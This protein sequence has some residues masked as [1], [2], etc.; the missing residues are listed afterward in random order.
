M[1][2]VLSQKLSPDQ[3]EGSIR[4]GNHVV[5]KRDRR[6]M[7][8]VFQD[9]LMLSN[10]TVRETILTSAELKLPV[11][12]PS[13]EK[14][15]RVDALIS[16]LGLSKV[17]DQSIGSVGQ[18][19]I[20][21]GER[22]RTAVANELV[23]APSVLFLD[24]PTSGLD[25]TTALHLI[26]TLR[27]LCD[28]GMTII[29]C[30]H[31]PRENIFAQFDRLL[32]L[33]D[34]HTAFF[35]QADECREYLENLRVGPDGEK[36]LELPPFTN[37]ADWILD[38]MS[39]PTVA[40]DIHRQWAN[41]QQALLDGQVDEIRDG[42][43]VAD[44]EHDKVEANTTEGVNTASSSAAKVT[45]SKSESA[46]T[47]LAKQPPHQL[48][49][50][51]SHGDEN[52]EEAEQANSCRV[53]CH[54]FATLSRRNFLQKRGAIISPVIIVNVLVTGIITGIMYWQASTALDTV[55]ALF[56]I[57]INQGYL[58][59]GMVMRVFP[60]EKFLMMR[61][62]SS[63]YYTLS[64]YFWAK[65]AVD[66]VASWTAPT[67]F[68]LIVY[69]C[70][71]LQAAPANFFLVL[72]LFTMF[73]ITAESFGFFISCAFTNFGTAISVNTIYLL[74]SM[75]VGGFYVQFDL[76]P[77]WL[78][79]LK[80]LGFITY[81]F[82]GLLRTQF[83]VG[84]PRFPCTAGRPGQFGPCYDVDDN[85]SLFEVNY[86]NGTISGQAILEF[87]STP[88]IA[89]GYCFLIL[90]LFAII[91]RFAA[92]LSLRFCRPGPPQPCCARNRPPAKAPKTPSS[93]DAPQPTEARKTKVDDDVTSS[94][95]VVVTVE[96]SESNAQ[97][98]MTDLQPQRPSVKKQLTNIDVSDRVE[99][100]AID[101]EN[102]GYEVIVD[103]KTGARRRILEGISGR[104]EP[105]RLVAL[106]GP[107]GAGKTT[108]LNTLALRDSGGRPTEETIIKF[109]GS[110]S[111]SAIQ[112][113]CGFVF[114][115]DLMLSR[116]TV[117]ETIMIAAE[118]K[119]PPGTPMARK[120]ERVD[121]VIETLRLQKVAHSLIG[122][123]GLRG[124]S[125]GERK[126]TAFATELITSPSILFL[127]EP[128]TG[129]D[130]NT[131][132]EVVRILSDLCL[133]RMS[134]ICSI[135]QPRSSIFQTF[136]QLLLLSSGQTA[137]F[138]PV[139]DVVRYF[140][141]EGLP[142]SKLPER[143]NVA[144][145][146]LDLLNEDA[147]SV[148]ITNAWKEKQMQDVESGKEVTSATNA[149]KLEPRA[150]PNC[151]H[152]FRVLL[153]RTSR[154]ESDQLFD[155]AGGV[156]TTIL[157]VIAGA[158][159]FQSRDIAG[160]AGVPFF[161]LLN[162]SFISVLST[163]RIFP[164]QRDLM[165]RETSLGY[166]G[167]VP[168]F[169][170]QTLFDSFA[171]LAVP[172]LFGTIL[173]LMAGLQLTAAAFFTCLGVLLL[174][175]VTAQSLGLL[176]ACSIMD[177]ALANAVIAIVIL[178]FMLLGGFYVSTTGI[179]AWLSWIK[180]LSFIYWGYSALLHNE[181]GNGRP[182]AVPEEYADFDVVPCGW[183]RELEYGECFDPIYNNVTVDDYPAGFISGEKSTKAFPCTVN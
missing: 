89:P 152:Q 183:A 75:L 80:W 55:G 69:W 19:G 168:Y 96:K 42:K 60:S 150:R 73:I 141:E 147:Q 67:I 31:Q 12:L 63:K 36:N 59:S 78:V 45:E 132:L 13:N 178:F 91:F 49:A 23:T 122:G 115:D 88:D 108:L 76:I 22:K 14:K 114:Q 2:N 120:N 136:D 79:W 74:T 38:L 46:G 20:S 111:D 149:L 47:D 165:L 106:M 129:L 93:A 18:R 175:V 161:L 157:A 151:C 156:S 131:A 25:S 98:E 135:H 53:W 112:S 65:C 163:T 127:D 11:S 182:D 179:L 146:V 7:G 116:L 140:Q 119:L 137:Y 82:T 171:G 29:C 113:R 64:A 35:G 180:Y 54:K 85:G 174:T 162:Q 66:A 99:P 17:K 125:G 3:V 105:G 50:A 48:H 97:I 6:N 68:I 26:Q 164:P 61:E 167:V 44:D 176:I 5:T 71:G 83:E 95:N 10:L 8:F 92:Y 52:E 160:L 34:G 166:Y 70:V 117:R 121:N 181:F 159:W 104:I 32:L 28:H 109:N 170:A 142:G 86:P 134:I 77:E 110:P 9:D 27:T 103:R 153:H 84:D 177:I 72:V 169:M 143:T 107:S 21:G 30:I 154:Q 118:L 4:I 172:A 139:N 62:R 40:V 43:T 148:A 90:L 133:S 158:I 57:L 173:Y 155:F 15:K 144:D 128:T 124:V 1:L 58:S 16:V 100:I 81:G 33:A 138:G 56:F 87:Q 41:N 126:R 39:D 51:D 37:V 102:L 130:S 145:W 24:E 94:E 101:F 123:Q